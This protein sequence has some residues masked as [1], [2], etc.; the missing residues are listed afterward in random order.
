MAI[1]HAILVAAFRKAVLPDAGDDQDLGFGSSQSGFPR[2]NGQHPA[3]EG[4]ECGHVVAQ[5][6]LCA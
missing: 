4:M 1:A 3:N 5:E 6:L 2:K